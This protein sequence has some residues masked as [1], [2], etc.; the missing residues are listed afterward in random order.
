ML[1]RSPRGVDIPQDLGRRV[2]TQGA[3][4]GV[5][6]ELGIP[7]H[8]AN[9]CEDAF[10]VGHSGTRRDLES[11]LEKLLLDGRTRNLFPSKMEQLGSYGGGN[12][13]G[14]CEVVEVADDARMQSA[15]D[16]FGLKHGHVAFLSHC[17]SRGWGAL[18]ADIHFKG[19]L[20]TF[21]NNNWALPGGD[22]HMVHAELGTAMANDYQIGRAHV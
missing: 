2:V 16:V 5:L 17:G 12:H 4:V 9:R 22:R 15:A 7:R 20:Q 19:M 10:H 6:D 18:L 8:W 14:E 1:F 3:S 11:R 21:V 13:F